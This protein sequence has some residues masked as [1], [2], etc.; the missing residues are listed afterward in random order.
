MEKKNIKLGVIGAGKMGGAIIKGTVKS[1]FLPSDNIFVFDLNKESV[2]EIKNNL[3]VNTAQNID[4]LIN[5][6]SAVLI[7][8]KPFA[9][10]SVLDSIKDKINNHLIISIMA[11]VST[12]RIE[13]KLTGA[14]VIRVMSNTPAL[15]NEGMSVVCKGNFAT[16]DEADLVLELFSKLGC[17]LK[18]DEKYID[19]VTAISGSG[20]AFFYYFIE[21]IARAGEKL[22][23][24]YKTCLKL[25]AQTALGAS[26]MIMNSKD[27]PG[28]LIKNV[29]TPGG[30]TEVGNNVLAD[31]KILYKTIKDTMEKAKSLG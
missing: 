28:V 17:A 13:N 22:G 12:T 1:G 23:L 7:A 19:I 14:H 27:T 3:K 24:D 11:G 31:F 20:P 18:I 8:T 25:S 29:T 15:V 30:C 2:N 5:S 4:E 10:D 9:A 26:R 6:T 21:E 16:D